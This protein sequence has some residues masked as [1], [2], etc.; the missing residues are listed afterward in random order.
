MNFVDSVWEIFGPLLQGVKSVLIDDEAVGNPLEL[1]QLLARER[2]SR[3][4]LVPSLLRLLLEAYFEQPEGLHKPK[5]WISSG[6]A[7]RADLCRKFYEVMPHSILLNLYGSSEVAA[8]VTWHRTD[9]GETNLPAA[10]IGLPISNTQIHILDSRL[11]LVPIGVTGEIYVGGDGLARGYHKRPGL[12]VPNDSYRT[13]F[14]N[15][16]A[17]SYTALAIWRAVV[18]TAGFNTWAAVTI[19]SR[20]AGSASNPERSKSP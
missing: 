20:F 15:F 4:V 8:D 13:H 2:V 14:V 6:E 17:S 12:N 11:Q 16:P 1:I 7:L 10:S 5:L 3:I 9:R 19:R 18:P